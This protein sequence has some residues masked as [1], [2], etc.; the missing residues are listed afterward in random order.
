M[1]WRGKKAIQNITRSTDKIEMLELQL[2][3]SIVLSKLD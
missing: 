1:Y 2:G 3:E